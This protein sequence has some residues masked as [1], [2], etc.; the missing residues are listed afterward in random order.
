MSAFLVAVKGEGKGDGVMLQ[1]ARGWESHAVLAAWWR[2]S[3]SGV[4]RVKTVPQ[5]RRPGSAFRGLRASEM[6]RMLV[7]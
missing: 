5:P 6:E 4:R 1:A 2:V 7:E 3:A